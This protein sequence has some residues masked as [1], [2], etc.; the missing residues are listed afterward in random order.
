[1]FVPMRETVPVVDPSA[2]SGVLSLL[3]VIIALPALGAVVILLLGN[4]R[5]SRFA[6]LLGCATVLGSFVLSVLTFVTLLGR[7]EDDRQVSQTLYTWVEGG[8]FKVDFG[9]LYDPLSALF[10]LLITGVGSLIHIYSVG[11]M[12]H[13][14]RRARFFA[15]LNLFVAAMLTLVLADNYLVLFLGWEGVGL[16]SYLL[17]GFW[18]H[19]PSA[20][21]AAKKAFVVNRVG[22]IGMA[23]GTMLV[24]ATFG[25]VG[26]AGV[27]AAADRASST[28]MLLLGLL[29]LLAACGKSAQV[30]L[31]SWLLDAMEG[32]TPV[33][34]L[35]HA[36]TMVTA[37]V[38]LVVRS[39]FIYDYSETA[40]TAVVVVG[41][42]TLLWGA[43]IGCAK[44]DI[45]KAL[46]GST[47]SQIGYMMLA[48]G[49]G[50]AGY[51]FAIFHLM[52]H[53]F[54]K[55]NLFLGAG[56]VMHAMD[57]DVD[58]RHYGALAKA[59]PVTFL[60]FSIGYL[61][62]IGVPPFAGFWSKDKIIEAGFGDNLVVGIAAMVG[63]GITAFYMTRLMLMTYFGKKRWQEGVHPH[64]SPKV[65]TGPL[66]ALA[67]LSALGGLLLLNDWI[68]D[69]LSPVVGSPPEESLPLPASVLSILIL[70]LVVVGVAVAWLT[71][72]RHEV[73][74]TAPAKVSFVTRAA[75]ADLYGD[76][77]NEELLMRPGDRFVNGL[78]AFDDGVVD[79]SAMGTGRAFGGMSST[80]RRLQTGFVRSYAL[81]V[82]GG[83]VVVVLALLAV[84]LA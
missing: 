58:M 72:G 16:A 47:M 28:T 76:A 17:I 34:A 39:N 27:S 54:F 4:A 33:S 78:V 83:A 21:V 67:A 43:I 52:T 44:D 56:S 14:V 26:F 64:E 75:R 8:G 41:V 19:K 49:L 60:T 45:K 12:E 25:T 18:Q 7:P 35:I 3:W 51:A 82:L 24:F 46:A 36:A 80:F 66:V 15:Y 84:N 20:A 23:L 37:G 1:M 70:V 42:V 5:T 6:H 11:Y 30:P 79:G 77:I 61:A 22:D 59:I 63:A 29:F 13:D 32:P 55:A 69:W 38:Y 10:L 53:G 48:A 2:T 74:L 50:P 81:S 71:V 62:I 40:Q 73:P 9:L 65:M 31:Q 57:D 68:V